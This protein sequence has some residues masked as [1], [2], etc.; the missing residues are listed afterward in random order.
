MNDDIYSL[1]DSLILVL[2]EEIEIY[3]KFHDCL[4]NESVILAGASMEELH[5]SNV[6]KERCIMEARMLEEA[7]TSIVD[8]I[9][10][11]LG[12]AEKDTGLSALSSYGNSS[13]KKALKECGA[14]LSTLA[15]GVNELNNKNKA[16]LD[17]SIL[18]VQKSIDFLG[19]LFSPGAVY[20]NSGRLKPVG[21]HG[22]ML[23]R[24]G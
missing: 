17:A 1:Y 9:N 12:N 24:K 10:A 4:V 5:E 6:R 16:L 15:T 2:E 8:K 20:M 19:Q 13:Q 11:G 21:E 7:R 3:R 22:N 14:L 18:Y 23:S